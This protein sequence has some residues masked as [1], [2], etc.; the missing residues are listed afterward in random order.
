MKLRRRELAK[1]YFGKKI[2]KKY[3]NKFI[4]KCLILYNLE[5]NFLFRGEHTRIIQQ[6]HNIGLYNK[7]KEYGKYTNNSNVKVAT[8]FF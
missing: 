8:F 6:T 5:I 1:K 7:N 4:R 3:L 2:L